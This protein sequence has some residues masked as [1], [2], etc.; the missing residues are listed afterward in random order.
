MKLS[1]PDFVKGGIRAGF[2]VVLFVACGWLLREPLS[3]NKY[4]A[5]VEIYCTW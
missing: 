2:G 1:P 3:F 4:V 5:G